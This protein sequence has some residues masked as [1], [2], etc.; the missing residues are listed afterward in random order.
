M[1][2]LAIKALLWFF[3]MWDEVETYKAKRAA[4]MSWDDLLEEKMREEE[5]AREL[6]QVAEERKA[7][8]RFDEQARSCP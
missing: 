1:K 6:E 3:R 5:K 4:G 8:F 2:R 7:A